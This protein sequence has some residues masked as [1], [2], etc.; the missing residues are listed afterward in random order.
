MN[1]AGQNSFGEKARFQRAAQANQPADKPK[2][3]D[4]LDSIRLMLTLH[5]ILLEKILVELKKQNATQEAL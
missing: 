3:S 2:L 5:G 4:Q 1:M